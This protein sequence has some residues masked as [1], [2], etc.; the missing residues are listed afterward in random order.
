MADSEIVQQFKE[1]T[2][3][4]SCAATFF[5]KSAGGNLEAAILSYLEVPQD[6]EFRPAALASEPAKGLR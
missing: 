4:D 2:S 3:A 5:L 6:H 1:V